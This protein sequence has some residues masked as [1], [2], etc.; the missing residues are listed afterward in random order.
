MTTQKKKAQVNTLIIEITRRCNMACDHCLRGDAQNLDITRQMLVKIFEPIA[1]IDSI[2]FTGGEPALR[3]QILMDALEVVKLFQIDVS[4]VYIVTNSKEVPDEFLAAVQAWHL[5]TMQNSWEFSGQRM[6]GHEESN[7]LIQML[8]SDEDR[9]EGAWVSLSMDCFHEDIPLENIRRLSS[10]PHLTCDKYQGDTS[11]HWVICEG[12]AMENGIGDTT[13]RELRP[14]YF[15][16]R[17]RSLD[18]EEDDPDD[19]FCV[20][21]EVMFS[22][23][24]N[25]LKCCDA[26]YKTQEEIKLFNLKELGANYTWVDKAVELSQQVTVH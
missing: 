23:T 18:I 3:P 16:E 5:Y 6:V 1:S 25:V 10:L 17:G 20:V 21:E 26:S 9:R 4:Q 7:R 22:V 19:Q 11:G 8:S 12:R 14:W 24:G 13:L 2:T 15:D